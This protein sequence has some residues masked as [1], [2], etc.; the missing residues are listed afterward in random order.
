[1]H[2]SLSVVV[3]MFGLALLELHSSRLLFETALRLF[4]KETCFASL[5]LPRSLYSLAMTDP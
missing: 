1:M 3:F 2:F 4:S 5:A